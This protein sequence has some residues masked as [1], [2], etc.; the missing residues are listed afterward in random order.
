M[1]IPYS[2]PLLSD[3][4]DG[5]KLDRE[6]RLLPVDFGDV[7]LNYDKNWFQDKGLAPP[8]SLEDLVDPK[9]A[10]LTVLENPATSSPGLAFLLTT[11]GHFG[12]PRI[13]GLLEKDAR[14]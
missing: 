14:E 4:D 10:G 11:I 3:I 5:L 9:Y 1:F 13:S 2:S 6:F 7:C 8:R 12:D